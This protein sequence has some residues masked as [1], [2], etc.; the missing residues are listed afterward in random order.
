MGST[1]AHVGIHKY[2]HHTAE[3]E[4]IFL[5]ESQYAAMMAELTKGLIPFLHRSIVERLQL[6]V[7]EPAKVITVQHLLYTLLLAP[8]SP[9]QQNGR[10]MNAVSK[11]NVL[12]PDIPITDLKR[13][14]EDNLKELACFLAH[15]VMPHPTDQSRYEWMKSILPLKYRPVLISLETVAIGNGKGPHPPMNQFWTMLEDMSSSQLVQCHLPLS[16][17]VSF[18][19]TAG[20]RPLR[21]STPGPRGSVHEQGSWELKRDTTILDNYGRL[22]RP[23]DRRRGTIDD[24]DRNLE[25][26]DYRRR[27]NSQ[28]RDGGKHRGQELKRPLDDGRRRSQDRDGE[29][30]KRREPSRSRSREP[31]Q[32]VNSA[33]DHTPTTERDKQ[34]ERQ[35][36]RS[37]SA[38]RSWSKQQMISAVS[39]LRQLADHWQQH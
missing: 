8:N 38:E 27:D 9:T 30:D 17:A 32:P 24:R 35:K 31:E 3:S 25:R 12:L 33:K 34:L 21:E 14:I 1:P 15:G 23:S 6:A 16:D 18:N 10:R 2:L 11:V 7:T 20:F 22:D 37:P 19:M 36:S 13:M 5:Y 4:I 28:D 29:A 39:V 26:G